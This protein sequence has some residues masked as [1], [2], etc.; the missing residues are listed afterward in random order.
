MSALEAAWWNLPSMLTTL[1][2]PQVTTL[3]FRNSKAVKAHYE[4]H[5]Y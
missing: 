3:D 1:E 4:V 2:L 5:T